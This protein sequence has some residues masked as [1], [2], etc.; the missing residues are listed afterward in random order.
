MVLAEGCGE[1]NY[2]VLRN[3]KWLNECKKM[4]ASQIQYLLNILN[5]IV[6]FLLLILYFPMR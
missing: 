3:A 2:L 5:L 6:L 4:W 1:I